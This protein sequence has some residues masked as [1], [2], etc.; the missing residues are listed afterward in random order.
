MQGGSL[1][2]SRSP[3]KKRN[4]TARSQPSDIG[5]LQTGPD[6][7]HAASRDGWQDPALSVPVGRGWSV[8]TGGTGLVRRY[9]WDGAA[10]SVPVGRGWSVGTGGTGLVRRYRK[11]GR[12]WSVGAGGTVWSVSTGGTGLVRRYRWDSLVRS[13]Q[14]RSGRVSLTWLPPAASPWCSHS[15]PPH[16]MRFIG[17]RNQFMMEA[18]CSSGIT[19]LRR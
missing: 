7:V 3:T 11:L 5:A 8:G 19:W 6:V 12:G 15:R 17:T 14:V 1:P 13:G 2:L 9:R 16:V 10:P 18:R 4:T